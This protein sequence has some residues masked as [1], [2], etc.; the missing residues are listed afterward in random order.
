MAGHADCGV[1]LTVVSDEARA[2]PLVLTLPRLTAD[3]KVKAAG[4]VPR[5][6]GATLGTHVAAQSPSAGTRV[7]RG[8]TVTMTLRIG[9]GS[10]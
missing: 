1:Q 10:D 4:L 5:F 3:R 6:T 9:P 8:T 2:I 7:P